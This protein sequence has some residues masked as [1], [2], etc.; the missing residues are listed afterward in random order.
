[1]AKKQ[2]GKF[3]KRLE[4]GDKRIETKTYEIDIC[5]INNDNKEIL[6]GEVKWQDNVDANK[7]LK[8]LKEKSK[9]VNWNNENRKEEYVIFAK[10]FKDKNIKDCTCYDLTDLEKIFRE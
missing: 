2:W 1:M 4:S 7:I 6:F 10:S 3:H 5:A 8:E 9:L